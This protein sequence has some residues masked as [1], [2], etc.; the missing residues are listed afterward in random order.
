[1]LAIN[2]TETPEQIVAAAGLL[3][4]LIVGVAVEPTDIVIALLVAIDGAAQ[5][6][7]DVIS[8]VT[9]WPFAKAVVV[10][11]LVFVPTFDPSTFHW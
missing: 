4:M 6:N 5:G 8:Q 2:V 10:Y 11:V 9:T 1:M 7:E 3:V